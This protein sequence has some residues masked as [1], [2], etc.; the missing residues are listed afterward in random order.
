MRLLVVLV[1][2]VALLAAAAPLAITQAPR[3][4]S[5]VLALVAFG[6]AGLALLAGIALLVRAAV[7]LRR[8]A[9]DGRSV[10]DDQ[11]PADESV[12]EPRADAGSDHIVLVTTAGRLAVSVPMT[13]TPPRHARDEGDTDQGSDQ[14]P[15]TVGHS[16][17]GA[18]SQSQ[19]QASTGPDPVEDAVADPSAERSAAF[20]SR[21]T[22]TRSRR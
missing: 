3:L 5:P 21:Y 19:A 22:T 4:H 17:G 8:A 6:V 15:V 18:E 7:L 14:E 16:G 12:T 13:V 10:R 11:P 1:V 2:T 9:P 20:A